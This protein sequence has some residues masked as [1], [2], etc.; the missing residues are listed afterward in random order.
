[1]FCHTDDAE[2]RFEE[3]CDWLDQSLAMALRKFMHLTP[4]G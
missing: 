3:L 1:M 2:D 4:G